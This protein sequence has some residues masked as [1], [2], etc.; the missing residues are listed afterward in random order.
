MRKML[1]FCLGGAL[2]K[3][4]K[5]SEALERLDRGTRLDRQQP[6]PHFQFAA[7]YSLGET[8]RA[9]AELSPFRDLSA[10]QK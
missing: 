7:V 8:D 4:G 3:I 6:G 9:A 10:E 5:T 1:H 2:V